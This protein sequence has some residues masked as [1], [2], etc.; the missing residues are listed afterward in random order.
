MNKWSFRGV[1]TGL[2]GLALLLL[3]VVFD[4]RYPDPLFTIGMI[5]GLG[6]VGISFLFFVLAFLKDLKGAVKTKDWWGVFVLVVAGAFILSRFF[7]R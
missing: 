7:R 6:A 1:R 4:L 5:L 2:G 3:L